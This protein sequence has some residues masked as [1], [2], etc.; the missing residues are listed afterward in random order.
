MCGHEEA[1]LG[2]PC[3]VCSVPAEPVSADTRRGMDAFEMGDYAA[4][5]KAF[6]K[7]LSKTP[8]SPLALRD[9][10]HAA[11]HLQDSAKAVEYYRQAIAIRP[12][13]IDAHFNLGLLQS[14]RGH[15]NDALFELLEVIQQRHPFK[16]GTFYLGLLHTPEQFIQQAHLQAGLL[17]K[18]RG[19]LE[20][21]MERFRAV[22]KESPKHLLA[23]GNLGDCLLA[24]ERYDEAIQVYKKAL[25]AQGEGADRDHLQ[26][27]LGVAYFKRGDSEKAVAQFKAVLKRDP[28]HVNAIYNLGQVYYQGGLTGRVQRDYE[29]FAKAKGGAAILYA[30]SKTIADAAGSKREGAG[31]ETSLIG[32]GPSLRRVRDLILRAAASDAT[33]L[34][35]GENGTGKELVARAIHQASTRH[36]KP[37]QAVACSAL[38]ETLLESE[39]FGHEK[40][41]FTGS[42][43]AHRPVRGRT[44]GNAFPRRNRRDQPGHPGETPAG[45]AGKGV[46]KGGRHRNRQGGRAYP[47]RHQSG[48]EA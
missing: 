9:C 20:R 5:L 28:D 1:P 17:F 7:V 10:G 36:D 42:G 35:L 48:P 6:E 4:S 34:I 46:R 32:P 40:G 15:I 11:F 27:D 39:L 21:A 26:N 44:P 31:E 37:F 45:V 22:L 25:S 16:Q 47:G 33:V 23:L 8:E 13:L 41:S 3:P 14:Q 12:R 24:L 43:P 18:Q 29:E 30:L 38:T 19:E 2:T